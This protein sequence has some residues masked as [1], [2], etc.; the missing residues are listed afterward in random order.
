M[1]YEVTNH[2]VVVVLRRW[3][4]A[5]RR[6]SDDICVLF[7]KID[8]CDRPALFSLTNAQNYLILSR[9]DVLLLVLSRTSDGQRSRKVSDAVTSVSF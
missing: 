4:S 8:E 2:Y 7:Y 3:C 5:R 6:E 9:A 1:T